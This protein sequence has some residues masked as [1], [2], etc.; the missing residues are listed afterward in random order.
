MLAN[1]LLDGEDTPRAQVL[2][3][4]V[5]FRPLEARI[6]PFGLVGPGFHTQDITEQTPCGF[7]LL[8]QAPQLPLEWTLAHLV[9][10]T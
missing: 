5:R 9:A 2:A 8:P 1:T 6:A 7:I 4:G 10:E 3:Q